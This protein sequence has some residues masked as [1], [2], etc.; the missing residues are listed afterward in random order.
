MDILTHLI[1]MARPQASVDLR[2]QM[3]GAF[4][5]PHEQVRD[6]VAPFHLVLAGSCQIE[7]PA[8]RLSLQ[9]GDF[10]LFPRGGAHVI[11]GVEAGEATGAMRMRYGG[12]LPLRRVGRGA[13]GVDLLCGHFVRARGAGELLFNALPDPLHVSLS[14]EAPGAALSAVV[15]LIRGE[16][17]TPQ[18]GSLAIVTALSQT[19]L[20]MALRRAGEGAAVEAG[21]LALLA[22]ARLGPSLQ[23]LLRDPGEAW[24]IEALGRRAAMSRASYARHFRAL[25]GMTVFEFISRVRMARACDLLCRSRRK[26]GDIGAEVGYQS[27]AAF[28]KAFRQHV[29]E[30]PGPYRR[31]HWLSE[32]EPG[33]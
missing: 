8:G 31:R 28:G 13:L 19:L 4:R 24:T 15:E 32:G 14:E 25:A 2:C 29:G 1:E 20:A 10:L 16:I 26:I 9:A 5:I 7:T 33:R 18:P 30:L 12:M 27:E 22:D 23:A 11:G 6:G 21:L 17:L 3:S